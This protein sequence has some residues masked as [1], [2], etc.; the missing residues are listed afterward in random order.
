MGSRH[1]LP[2]NAAGIYEVLA[3]PL[4]NQYDICD[5]DG[6]VITNV[7]T[8]R[9][10]KEEMFS[11]FFDLVKIRKIC[12]DHGPTFAERLVYV[13]R[14]TVRIQGELIPPSPGS[15]RQP[16]IDAYGERR[17]KRQG[18]GYGYWKEKRSTCTKSK[19]EIEQ[20]AADKS[21]EV[22]TL[23]KQINLLQKQVRNGD[24]VGDNGNDKR[25]LCFLRQK[26]KQAKKELYFWNRLDRTKLQDSGTSTINADFYDHEQAYT[27]DALGSRRS[28]PH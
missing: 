7:V 4:T 8:A 13:D 28:Q 16:F 3:S 5:T 22:S 19:A 23:K 11:S 21:E 26:T 24:N 12:E 18:K 27:G 2:L 15:N 25:K 1:A 9:K 10:R 14:Y 17:K 20:L 6:A